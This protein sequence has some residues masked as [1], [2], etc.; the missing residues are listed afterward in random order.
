MKTATYHSHPPKHLRVF[1]KKKE[2]S[3]TTSMQYSINSWEQ[4]SVTRLQP[5]FQV[6]QLTHGRLNELNVIFT[7]GVTS[8]HKLRGLKQYTCI[9]HSSV[10]PKSGT[11]LTGPQGT[12][13]MTSFLETL[14][15][16]LGE[17]ERSFL[18]SVMLFFQ[19]F[20]EI[21]IYKLKILPC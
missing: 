1:P 19:T 3:Y 8:Y 10:G 13:I 5:I 21:Y 20:Y 11:G 9:F 15:G 14:G 7:T 17:E 2:L 12:G 4:L 18:G 6:R 16:R